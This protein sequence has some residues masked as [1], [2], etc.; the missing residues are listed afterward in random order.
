MNTNYRRKYLNV[1]VM[2]FSVIKANIVA[3]EDDDTVTRGLVRDCHWPDG[4]WWLRRYLRCKH[5]EFGNNNKGELLEM[6][7]SR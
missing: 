7:L 6:S 1:I 4:G 2:E 3:G 5:S